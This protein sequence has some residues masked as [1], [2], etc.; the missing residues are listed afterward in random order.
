MRLM[1][2]RDDKDLTRY[3]PLALQSVLIQG[4]DAPGFLARMT[5]YDAALEPAFAALCTPQGLVRFLFAVEKTA[6]GFRAVLP[7]DAAGSFAAAMSRY[8]LR[9]R[10]EITLEALPVFGRQGDARAM[11]VSAQDDAESPAPRDFWLNQ[12]ASGVAWVFAANAGALHPASLGLDDGRTLSFTKGCYVGQEIVTRMHHAGVRPQ[13]LARFAFEGRKVPVP[14]TFLA[15]SANASGRILYALEADA[16]G[17]ALG[18]VTAGDALQ[19]WTADGVSLRL[20]SLV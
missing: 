13:V 1:S 17:F 16:G 7:A 12:I 4:E 20:L 3:D 14:G 15:G 8:V 18:C 5:T 2:D 19:T 6:G 11:R 9:D 10:V